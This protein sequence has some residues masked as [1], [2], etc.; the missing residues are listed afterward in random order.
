MGQRGVPCEVEIGKKI[1]PVVFL[2]GTVFRLKAQQCACIVEKL[3]RKQSSSKISVFA[4]HHGGKTSNIDTNEDITSLYVHD[5]SVSQLKAHSYRSAHLIWTELRWDEWC[6]RSFNL[7][8]ARNQ[9]D[10]NRNIKRTT[11]CR[12]N[13]N[14][15]AQWSFNRIYQVAPI[16][17][18]SNIS[19]HWSTRVWSH[20][21]PKRHID[22]FSRFCGISRCWLTYDRQTDRQTDRQRYHAM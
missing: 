16:C 21:N 1:I 6:E 20:L 11:S 22:R 10:K 13:G 19:F 15:S 8:A 9:K 2:K 12:S 4:P 7:Y 18:P 3:R 14:A 5:M 17:Y